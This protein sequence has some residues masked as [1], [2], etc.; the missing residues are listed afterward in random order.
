MPRYYLYKCKDCYKY[1]RILRCPDGSVPRRIDVTD[2]VYSFSSLDFEK[3]ISFDDSL[4]ELLDNYSTY[5]RLIKLPSRCDL[6]ALLVIIDTALYL[7]SKSIP[8][9]LKAL[10][11]R[12]EIG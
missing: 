7:K 1:H 2:L 8:S 6:E 5:K 4:R 11:I 10:K 12:F 9:L 3:L